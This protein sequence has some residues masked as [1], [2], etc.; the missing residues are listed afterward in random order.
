MILKRASLAAWTISLALASSWGCERGKDEVS[1]SGP[2]TKALAPALTTEATAAQGKAQK[3]ADLPGAA[4]KADSAKPVVAAAESDAD[5]T[6]EMRRE[7]GA[8]SWI[9]EDVTYYGATLRIGEQWDAFMKSRAFR[10]VMTLPAVQMLLGQVLQHPAYQQFLAASQTNPLLAAAFEVAADAVSQELILYADP[11][12]VPFLTAVDRI[13]LEVMLGALRTAASKGFVTGP[14]GLPFSASDFI[15]KVLEHEQVLRF[16]PLVIGFRLSKPEAAR[17]LM[18]DVLKQY[19]AL[20]PSA[21]EKEE[22]PGGDFH[23]LRLSAS[24]IPSEARRNFLTELHA[25]GVAEDLI[26]KLDAFVESQTLALSIGLRGDYLLLSAGKSSEH[27]K[28]L[29]QGRSLAASKALAP[30]RRHF[31]P[32]VISLT[33]LTGSLSSPGKLPVDLLLGELEKLLASMPAEDQP[34]GFAP[35]VKKDARSFLEDLNRYLPDPAPAVSVTFLNHG[36]ET[37][38]FSALEPYSLD[39]SKP[40]SILNRAGSSPLFAIASRSPPSVETYIRLVHWVKVAY[41]Y[42]E[43]YVLPR[44]S[45]TERD[46][47]ARFQ[48][49]FIPAIKELHETT[50]KYF[51]PAVDACQAAFVLDDAGKLAA[52]P[53]DPEPLARPLR[54][55]RPALVLEVNDVDKFK[56]AFS[57]YRDTVNRF[58]Q[59]AGPELGLDPFTIP[60]PFTRPHAG[61][62][63]YTY[64]F[65][66]PPVFDLLP[67]VLI[68]GKYVVLSL[69]LDQSKDIVESSTQRPE[70]LVKLAAEAGSAYR[71]ELARL[72]RLVLEDAGIIVEHMGRHDQ[73][74]ADRLEFVNFHLS[75]IGEALG[76]FKS[77]NGRVYGEEGRQVHHSWLEV[78]DLAEES[79]R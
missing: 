16:P 73:L 11:S 64:P 52:L 71:L 61:G 51:N 34:E 9:P 65:P 5:L 37:Y 4:A 32:G 57:E 19:G 21:V 72:S 31:K 27:L 45:K 25:K 20:L 49:L 12:W 10:K 24:I 7:L 50:E 58:F 2:G 14:G 63:L 29:G 54:Y 68:S 43:K 38:S 26:K 56:Q 75:A 35:Q 78:E 74:P 3:G 76:T 48:R 42:F 36:I 70:G 47:V 23:T 33:Y 66:L 79:N 77:Y 13:Y 40:L 1:P 30:V 18:T 59:K 67:H 15:T 28:K 44:I 39:A 22:S 69:S 17:N 41:G 62:T 60:E 55:P 53:A 6:D 46:E 8:A